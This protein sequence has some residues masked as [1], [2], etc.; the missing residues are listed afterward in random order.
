ME[1]RSPPGAPLG[2]HAASRATGGGRW[3]GVFELGASWASPPTNSKPTEKAVASRTLWQTQA[4]HGLGRSA[5]LHASLPPADVPTMASH[6]HASH[7]GMS[8]GP[9]C[10]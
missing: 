10:N 5:P 8:G 1:A 7:T 3:A 6:S 4:P 2:V 9:Q